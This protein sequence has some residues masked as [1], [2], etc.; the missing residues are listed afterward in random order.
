METAES[1]LQAVGHELPEWLRS[2]FVACLQSAPKSRDE[3]VAAI[4]EFRR[5]VRSLA[6]VDGMS[7]PDYALELADRCM[8]LIRRTSDAQLRVVQAAVDYLTK[9]DDASSDE[10]SLVGMEDDGKVVAAVERVIN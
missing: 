2:T 5:E 4:E 9:C 8:A 3:L 1:L 6:E 10:I 7:D